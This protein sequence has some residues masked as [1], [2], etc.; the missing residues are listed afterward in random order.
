MGLPNETMKLSFHK[1][2]INLAEFKGNEMD[3]ETGGHEP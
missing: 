2:G 3:D 1:E